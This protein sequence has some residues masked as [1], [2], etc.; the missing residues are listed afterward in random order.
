MAWLRTLGL[1][2]AVAIGLVGAPAPTTRTMRSAQGSHAHPAVSIGRPVAAANR[3]CGAY[4]H[5]GPEGVALGGWRL[6]DARAVPVPSWIS[7]APGAASAPRMPA[8]GEAVAGDGIAQATPPPETPTASPEPLASATA[9]APPTARQADVRLNEVLAAPGGTDWDGDG[10]ANG[11]DEWLEVVNIGASD[12]DL[13]GWL[14]DDVDDDGSPGYRIPDGHVV[15]ARGHRVYFRRETGL[16]LD[17]G[18]D[19]LQLVDPEG[20]TADAV[21]FGPS[22][23]DGGWARDPDGDGGWTDRLAPS[24]GQ[25]NGAAGVRATAAPAPATS[26]G[27]G[28]PPT[29]VATAAPALSSTLPLLIS[30][31]LF[32]PLAS[33][34]DAAAE[35]VEL[36]NRGSEPVDLAGWSLGDR[37]AWDALPS[38]AVPA[39][40][41][42]VVAASS[43][44]WEPPPAALVVVADG[45]IGGGLGN[46]GDVVRLRGPAGEI[47]DAVSYGDNLDAFDPSVPAPAAGASIERLPSDRDTDRAAD[48]RHQ[49]DPSPGRRGD[50]HD[51]PPPVRL[52]EIMPAPAWIDWDGNGTADHTD[53]WIELVSAASYPVHLAGWSLVDGAA[54]RNGWRYRFDAAA[55]IAP[56]G[57]VVVHR[58]T[59]GL[60][61]D[62]GADHVQ[63]L[64]PDGTPADAARWTVAPGYDR[65]WGRDVGG[66]G[67]TADL[68][69]TPGQPNRRPAAGERHAG[70][71]VRERA[72][73][74]RNRGGVAGRADGRPARKTP[75]P[76]P[77][78][79]AELRAMRRGT[80]VVV[81]GRVTA[82]PNVLGSRTFYL[83]DSTGGVR[84]FLNPSDQE[85][86]PFVTGDPV[87]AIGRL[88]D[89]RGERQIVLDRPGDAW[90]NGDGA[91]V[92]A[93]P[94]TTGSVGEA[95]EGR[96]VRLRAR[97]VRQ[98]PTRLTVDDGTGAA[99]VVLL[100]SA[101]IVV[102]RMPHGRWIEVDGIVSQSAARAPWEGG[103]RVLPRGAAD[104]SPWRPAASTRASGAPAADRAE[105]DAPR[106]GQPS[107][108]RGAVRLTPWE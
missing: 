54:A 92:A 4:T 45:R 14:L 17:D 38:S 57:F 13:R 47:V 49:P 104:L 41:F 27:T 107:A 86:R 56:G 42:V 76:R 85:H 24:P 100:R 9:G 28:S 10:R 48:W 96:L 58:A 40:G 70:D 22:L 101:A 20:R 87:S 106:R 33:G 50:V 83:G 93:L 3:H 29:A 73:S 75:P 68:I 44:A 11:E 91:P 65:V 61:L 1:G 18:G 35:W 89:Y 74:G 39:G 15:P 84:V 64:R 25:P 95:L 55:T 82:A 99:P 16:A 37:G 30:E 97:V 7:P 108:G 94:V 63:L 66:G 5:P 51:G 103:Y 32:D 72:A 2:V 59:S 80:R 21:A 34:N 98:T 67:W 60:A 53:E 77:L 23:P 6:S 102:P 36:H 8:G 43:A 52:N 88:S 46:G 62:N 78:A 105:A 79:L 71:V 26:V 31:V 12:L 69:A 81:H 90:W 19:R